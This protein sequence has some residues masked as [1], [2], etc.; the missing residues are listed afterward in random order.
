LALKGLSYEYAAVHLLKDGGQ[1]RSSAYRS[2]NPDCLVPTLE[3]GPHVL[4]QS[5]AI[6]FCA[7]DASFSFRFLDVA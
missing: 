2:L 1:Q 3:D 4:T 5:L 6:V 7:L